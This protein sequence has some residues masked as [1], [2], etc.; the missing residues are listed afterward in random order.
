[1]AVSRSLTVEPAWPLGTIADLSASDC[2][3][4]RE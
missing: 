4:K 1:M 3:A 2:I